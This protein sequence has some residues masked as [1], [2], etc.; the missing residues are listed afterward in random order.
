MDR[1]SIIV[2]VYKV[3]GY[4]HECVNSIL[5]QT[6]K[7]IEIIL[8]DDGS[9]DSCPVICDRYAKQD[10]RVK[11]IH[12]S[13]GGL[14]DARNSGIRA[15]TGDYVA[16]IDSD[17]YVADD[18]IEKIYRCAVDTGAD[19]VCCGM[20]VIG[21]GSILISAPDEVE[22]YTYDRLKLLIQDKGT[23]DYYMNKLFS[24]SLLEN[25]ELPV[26]KLFEDIYSMHFL[27]LKAHKVAWINE[28]LYYYRI[29]ETG[30]SHSKK[31][32]P[33]SVDFVYANQ[34][35]YEFVSANYP[36]YADLS[37]RKYAGAILRMAEVYSQKADQESLPDLISSLT[38]L[39]LEIY[40]KVAESVYCSPQIKYEIKAI[41]KGYNSWKSYYIRRER[42]KKLHNRPGLQSK[43]SRLLKW[44]FIPQE[45]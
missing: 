17:D 19:I 11:V 33:K 9:P 16:F 30:I 43:I 32:N 39:S 24:R 37:L 4:L 41:A 12:Q 7:N 38:R 3:E 27:F 29:N 34:V 22:C 10:S 5:A 6:Y 25:F 26:G 40:D 23:G 13:N 2:P 14:S 8:I 35:Q 36:E 18:F 45:E 31:L 44:G 21:K 20:T 15:A 28:N 42:V 1:I